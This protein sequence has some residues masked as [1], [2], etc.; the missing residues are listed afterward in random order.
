MGRIGV[1]LAGFIPGIAVRVVCE[2]AQHPGADYNPNPGW[3]Q[4]VSA[5]G[6]LLN[7]PASSAS[8]AAKWRVSPR[9]RP[10]AATTAPATERVRAGR[11]DSAVDRPSSL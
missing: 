3:L 11:A 8:R 1:V 6:V 2:L 4:M 10:T 9:S 7:L 5:P